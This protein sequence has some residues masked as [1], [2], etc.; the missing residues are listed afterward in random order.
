[1]VD[2]VHSKRVSG[3]RRSSGMQHGDPVS[4]TENDVVGADSIVNNELQLLKRALSATQNGVMITDAGALDDPIVFVNRAFEHITGY[5]S[6]E[7]LGQNPRFLQAG[8]DAQPALDELRENRR[9]KNDDVEWT[10]VLRNYKKDGTPFWNELSTAAVHE[11]DERLTHHIGIISDVTEREESEEALRSSEERFRTLVQNASDMINVFG[12]DGTVLYASPATERIL[13]YEAGNFV[14]KSAFDYV[15]PDDAAGVFAACARAREIGT[16]TVEY[17]ARHADGSWRYLEAIGSSLSGFPGVPDVEGVVVNSRDVTERRLAEEKMSEAEARFRSAF[18]DVAVGMSL[19]DPESKRYLR[20]NPALCEMLGYPEE[21]LLR[22]TFL[23][24][25]HP[26]DREDTSDYVR[27]MIAGEI[28]SYRHEKRYVRADGRVMWA[29]TNVSVVCDAEGRP[30]YFV[31]QV[32]DITERK[33]AEKDLGESHD[34]LRA[35]MEGT[36]DAVFVKDLKGRY[37]MI[38]GAGAEAL[39]KSVEEIIGRD[40]IELFSPED[41]QEVVEADEK[42]MASGGTYTTEDTKSAEGQM[43]RTFLS[44]KGPYR[45]GEGNVAGMFGISRDITDRKRAE[46]ALRESEQRLQAIASNAPVITFA[47][48]SE[49][50]FTFENG[51]A[52]RT[53]GLEPGWSIGRSVFETYA[54]LPDVLQNVRRALAGEEVVATVEIGNMTFHAIYTPQR[55]ESGEV[56]GIIGVATNITE[57]RRLEQKLEH[58]STHDPLTGL[59]NRRLLFGRLSHALR[60]SRQHKEPVSLLYLDLDGFKEVN[61]LHGHEMGDTLLEAAAGRIKRC[62][63]PSDTAARIGGDEFIVLL[64][65]VSAERAGE[66]ARRAEA[67]FGPPFAIGERKIQIGASVGIAYTGTGTKDATQ[68]LREADRQMYL[69][70]RKSGEPEAETGTED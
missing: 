37:L 69:A 30:L 68:L 8:D 54:E 6:E 48:D 50:V 58:R 70:K 45:D 40:D 38:N 12:A 47:I 16:A 20:V 43:A 25:T 62:L 49:G 51:A 10:G 67:A 21:E 11:E 27:R 44:T 46:E 17:R 13:G 39:G 24:F 35:V 66:V 4:D 65:G 52:L 41:G 55:D 42:V 32:Q 64:E 28:D 19:A 34:L 61:D 36:T 9:S 53:L 5:T 56:E 22:M 14:G 18:D 15:H 59:A 33:Q 7:V 57:R 63:R 26:E 3:S 31:A 2:K 23:D 60:Y 29:S 1:M